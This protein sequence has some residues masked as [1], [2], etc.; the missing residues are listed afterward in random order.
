MTHGS[1]G[2]VLDGD[3]E[4]PRAATFGE[5]VLTRRREGE[6]PPIKGLKI[7]IARHRAFACRERHQGFPLFICRNE[8]FS[9][10]FPGFSRF[11]Q[12]L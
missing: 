11:F 8:H 6:D 4:L 3:R 10:I 7:H 12:V 1:T 5:D 9:S 2:G